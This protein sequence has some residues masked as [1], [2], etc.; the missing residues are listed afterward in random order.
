MAL[1]D[2]MPMKLIYYDVDADEALI[3]EALDYFESLHYGDY[4][5]ADVLFESPGKSSASRYNLGAIGYW[6][7][8]HKKTP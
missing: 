3:W 4:F 8:V 2:T 5:D 6:L 7:V 1:G